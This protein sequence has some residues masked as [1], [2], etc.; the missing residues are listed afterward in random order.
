M[1]IR[2]AASTGRLTVWWVVLS[3]FAFGTPGLAQELDV[4]RGPYLQQGAHDRIT[5]RWRTSLTTDSR[6]LC[7]T[8][9]GSLAVCGENL[10][11][12]TEHEV[13]L[14]GLIPDTEYYYAVGSTS[15]IL[16]GND[17]DHKFRTAPSP[18]TARPTRIW[19]LGDSGTGN[20]HAAAV[21][22]AYYTYSMGT[23]THVW[24]MLGDN[25]YNNGTDGEYQ[26]KL[27]DMYPDT[28]IK[29]V[30]WPTIGNHDA[31]TSNSTTLT[32]PYY[33]SFTLPDNAQAVGQA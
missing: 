11:Q 17:T 10:G 14:F 30:L 27:F 20:A 18:G 13:D 6:V 25:A 15:Q 23:E 7:G 32:G 28:L 19:I 33:D 3:A 4:T 24:L 2:V 31:V 16:A 26:T 9:Q 12:T 8:N 21:R 29:T 22:D 5:V 1:S